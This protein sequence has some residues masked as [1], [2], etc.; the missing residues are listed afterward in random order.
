MPKPVG[1]IRSKATGILYTVAWD[2]QAK[3]SWISADKVI[4]SLTGDGVEN[5]EDAVA[6]SKKY[7]NNHPRLY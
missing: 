1:K 4:W 2:R 3:T 6:R 7:I 5:A